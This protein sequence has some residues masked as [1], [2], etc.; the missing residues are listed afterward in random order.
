M[1]D[2]KNIGFHL[3]QVSSGND[4]DVMLQADASWSQDTGTTSTDTTSTDTTSNGKVVD[5]EVIPREKTGQEIVHAVG[6]G[7]LD[8]YTVV[9][10]ETQ[11]NGVL[12]AY[13]TNP[14]F[15]ANQIILLTKVRFP[16]K[17]IR[18][19][20]TTKTTF[21][22]TKIEVDKNITV[23]ELKIPLVSNLKFITV[24]AIGFAP[25]SF[26][27]KISPDKK[28]LT[29]N[30]T[31]LVPVDNAG[32]VQF[33]DTSKWESLTEEEAIDAEYNSNP[34]II[35]INNF[36]KLAK[37]VLDDAN[38]ISGGAT[39]AKYV[40]VSNNFQKIQNIINTI[41]VWKSE[42]A[43]LSEFPIQ[44]LTGLVA[45]CETAFGEMLIAYS[46][47]DEISDKAD[48]IREDIKKHFDRAEEKKWFAD[49]NMESAD[50]ARKAVDT[51]TKG[52]LPRRVFKKADD[53]IKLIEED[54]K[55]INDKMWFVNVN[56]D[57]AQKTDN[58]KELRRIRG[59][60][61]DDADYIKTHE[62]Q[63]RRKTDR[64]EGERGL[65]GK[66]LKGFKAVALVLPRR[67][68][69]F[70]IAK[71]VMGLATAID[72]AAD[73]DSMQKFLHAWDGFG[74]SKKAMTR[75]INK[76]KTKK[77]ILTKKDAPKGK[78]SFLPPDDDGIL[79]F[80]DDLAGFEDTEEGKEVISAGKGLDTDEIK[81]VANK[82]IEEAGKAKTVKG[83]LK[84]L[85]AAAGS[86]V[87]VATSPEGT[88]IAGAAT[89]MALTL[90]GFL[91]E[92]N[93][94]QAL[95]DI[96]NKDNGG[97]DSDDDGLLPKKT[98]WTL[99]G[100]IGGGIAVLGTVSYFVF[101]KKK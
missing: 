101:G 72:K 81:K 54:Y 88:A 33:T 83:A 97:S 28:T 5:N 45:T 74:G 29:I 100:I 48:G 10:S 52:S 87:A 64:L 22:G 40:S 7:T 93:L 80:S 89:G 32:Y 85:V 50:I 69:A 44:I 26:F 24:Y 91:P 82:A 51:A 78:L 55:L 77:P 53:W 9:L 59:N 68:V 70:M 84:A 12:E 56:W 21:A 65:I 60:M 71:N 47:L 18:A 98:D 6:M 43:K 3:D 14:D 36:Y 11:M 79:D 92:G 73:P 37:V 4:L 17:S 15:N 16:I 34:N 57:A 62:A 67:F 90:V 1:K 75:W 8:P 38:L 76:G 95:E 31:F 35:K 63:M 39:S 41:S 46:E 20:T 27:A 58:K 99:I 30:K 49:K 19:K 23:I 61:N 94:K 86:I 13:K 96:M 66:I 42:K 25:S 2:D